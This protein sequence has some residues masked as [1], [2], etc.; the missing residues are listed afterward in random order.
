MNERE[1]QSRRRNEEI[2]RRMTTQ[3][4]EYVNNWLLHNFKDCQDENKLKAVQDC[5]GALS[6]DM[7]NKVFS[8][9]GFYKTLE[10]A[11]GIFTSQ[12]LVKVIFDAEDLIRDT[13]QIEELVS[14]ERQYNAEKE[15]I[16]SAGYVE[17]E[18]YIISYP[19]NFGIEP[20]KWLVTEFG[21]YGNGA[22]RPV[23]GCPMKKDGKPYNKAQYISLER[24][25]DFVIER[26]I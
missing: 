11:K 9:S 16:A 13:I 10:C 12:E 14:K 4:E 15:C 17:N 5:A 25:E 8:L 26:V 21:V 20:R 22:P 19:N 1:D 24:D 3:N 7:Q 23:R 18:L 2:K 6:K